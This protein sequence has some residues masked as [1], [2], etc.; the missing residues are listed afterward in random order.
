MPNMMRVEKY[1]C[2]QDRQKCCDYDFGFHRKEGSHC[3]HK[4][5]KGK[6]RSNNEDVVTFVDIVRGNSVANDAPAV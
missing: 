1:R 5:H 6:T 3:G 4:V 2:C